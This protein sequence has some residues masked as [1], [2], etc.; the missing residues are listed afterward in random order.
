MDINT[1]RTIIGNDSLTDDDVSA[2]LLRA[3]KLAVNQ[4]YWKPDDNPEKAELERFY[5]RYEFEIY[6]IARE[7]YSSNSRGGLKQ[8]SELGVTRI[9]GGSGSETVNAAISAIPPKTYIS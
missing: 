7:V 8:F 3:Q 4:R 1:A 5:D 9:W 2:L 6:D